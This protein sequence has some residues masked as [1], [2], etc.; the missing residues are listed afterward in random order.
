MEFPAQNVQHRSFLSRQHCQQ[1]RGQA[2]P[3]PGHRWADT[4]EEGRTRLTVLGHET[5][6][7]TQAKVQ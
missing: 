3:L 5:A 2:A 6:G 4:E 1:Q 7:H